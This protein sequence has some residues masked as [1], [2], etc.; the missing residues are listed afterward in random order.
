[1]DIARMPDREIL[2]V[3]HN[4]LKHLTRKVED[5]EKEVKGELKSQDKRITTNERF[6]WKALGVVAIILVILIPVAA[7]LGGMVNAW[8]N[9]RLAP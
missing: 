2:I 9:H 3:V 6:R 4:D 1:M 7:V 8:F 5:L